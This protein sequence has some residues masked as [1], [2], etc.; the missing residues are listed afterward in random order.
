MRP[1]HKLNLWLRLMQ[2]VTFV[3][4]IAGCWKTSST[5][6][7]EWLCVALGEFLE[8]KLFSS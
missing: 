1:E 4:M 5:A 2:F 3:Y 7:R 8:S 6:M